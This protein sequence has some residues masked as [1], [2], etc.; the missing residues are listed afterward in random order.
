MPGSKLVSRGTAYFA[1]IS[2]L[3]L[4]II[5]A[6]I[7]NDVKKVISTHLIP[8]IGSQKGGMSYQISFSLMLMLMLTISVA[9]KREKNGCKVCVNVV[10]VVVVAGAEMPS[11]EQDFIVGSLLWTYNSDIEKLCSDVNIFTLTP[12]SAPGILHESNKKVP[13]CRDSHLMS[14]ESVESHHRQGPFII[15][16]N[17]TKSNPFTEGNN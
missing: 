17:S 11:E 5:M 1:V 4:L 6:A 12:S 14:G 3:N 13:R 15:M 8:I 10:V 9:Y 7:A 16:P 2:T